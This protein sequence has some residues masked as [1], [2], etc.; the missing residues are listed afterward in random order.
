MFN[1]ALF[2]P[3]LALGKA[4]IA[5]PLQARRVALTE[6]FNP[7]SRLTMPPPSTPRVH[8]LWVR[9][10]DRCPRWAPGRRRPHQR[11]L[12]SIPSFP[13]QHLLHYSM[14]FEKMTLQLGETVE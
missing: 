5:D 7:P 14:I 2:L 13:C 1:I 4:V 9:Q 10:R 8:P 3:I 12:Q 11:P 6:V